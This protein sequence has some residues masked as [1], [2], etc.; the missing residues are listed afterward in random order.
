[1]KIINNKPQPTYKMVTTK[2]SLYIEPT[3]SM[4]R[5]WNAHE[6]IEYDEQEVSEKQKAKGIFKEI[7]F[8]MDEKFSYNFP[9]SE[10]EYLN[11]RKAKPSFRQGQ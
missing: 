11:W 7:I 10:I 5:I 3:A 6:W 4:L 8:K 2:K 9:L 1:M